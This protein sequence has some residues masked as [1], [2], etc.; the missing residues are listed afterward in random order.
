MSGNKH[1]TLLR[2]RMDPAQKMRDEF[3]TTLRYIS[4]DRINNDLLRANGELNSGDAAS[5]TAIAIVAPVKSSRSTHCTEIWPYA[6][7]TRAEAVSA[8]AAVT[9]RVDGK[10]ES[11]PPRWRPE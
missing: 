4:Q 9:D 3:V 1:R 2:T 8:D 6:L 11:E 7:P 5:G 10:E